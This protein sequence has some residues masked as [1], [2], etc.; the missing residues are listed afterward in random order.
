MDFH[1]PVRNVGTGVPQFIHKVTP[2][3]EEAA[4]FPYFLQRPNNLRRDQ[5]DLWPCL[6]VQKG[7]QKERDEENDSWRQGGV[8]ELGGD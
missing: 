1:F 3:L 7:P 8:L 4:G 2:E 6:T 5:C